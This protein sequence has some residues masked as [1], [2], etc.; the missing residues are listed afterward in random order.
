MTFI[1]YPTSASRNAAK[2]IRANL[3]RKRAGRQQ[4]GTAVGRRR[5]IQLANRLPISLQ[6]VKRTYSFL[7]RG[8]TYDSGDWSDKGTISYNLW[9]GD[10][11]LNWT[12]QILKDWQ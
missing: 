12:R 6:T 10:A 4:A 11:M 3:D 1:S 5:A 7:S 9:G 8:K 2:A